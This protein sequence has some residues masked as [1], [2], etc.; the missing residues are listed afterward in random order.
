ML[1]SHAILAG[2][3]SS[4]RSVPEIQGFELGPEAVIEPAVDERVVAGA[5][6]SEP[7]KGEVDSVI[8]LDDFAGEQHHVAVQGEP[9][10]GKDGH[11]QHQ[12]LYGHALAATVSGRLRHRHVTDGV[13]QPHLLD[14]D[15][16][17]HGDD[18]QR[19]DVKQEE[20]GQVKILPKE[21]R[22]GWETG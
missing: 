21:V 8:G 12:H 11:H 14:Q 4:L 6:G 18:S 22:R 1:T 17:G 5:A 15:D 3:G 13:V 16:V 2:V 7:M 19:Q 9:A 20:G 10:D